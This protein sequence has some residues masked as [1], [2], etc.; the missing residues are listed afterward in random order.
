[1]DFQNNLQNVS[2]QAYKDLATNL[3]SIPIPIML[4]C[5]IAL[6]MFILLIIM[7]GVYLQYLAKN[8]KKSSDNSGLPSKLQN[9]GKCR[10]VI[11]HTLSKI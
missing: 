8:P 5:K 9:L 1:M 4:K 3:C 11:L 6:S 7:L 10:N 2:S